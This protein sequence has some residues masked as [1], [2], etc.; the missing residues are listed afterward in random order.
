MVVVSGKGKAG[1][2]ITS[3]KP[4]AMGDGPRQRVS[5]QGDK[6]TGP[7]YCWQETGPI[8]TML[9]CS[10]LLGQTMGWVRWCRLCVGYRREVL[11]RGRGGG[12]GGV[13]AAADR[14][15]RDT[16]PCLPRYACSRHPHQNPHAH[17]ST[18]QP[19]NQSV[20][21]PV[22]PPL[23]QSVAADRVVSCPGRRQSP[24]RSAPQPQV[25][26][27]WPG[28][29]IAAARTSCVAV[30]LPFCAVASHLG[31][32]RWAG[33]GRTRA[34]RTIPGR[35]RVGLFTDTVCNELVV[36]GGDDRQVLHATRG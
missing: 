30:L 19:I 27:R 15:R 2:A 33:A 24:P 26:T 10:G 13:V 28:P 20:N 34:V 36:R 11:Y 31:L 23:S 18:H 8:S 17:S 22:L 12:G 21:Q 32:G 14:Q 4:D 9:R 25:S 5:A 29:P 35:V 1:A 6:A 7:T 16:I 3:T